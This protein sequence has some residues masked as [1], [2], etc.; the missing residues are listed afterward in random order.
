MKPILLRLSGLQS[1]REMQE[2]DFARLC[3]AGVFGIFGS[4]GS[5]KSSIL[6]AMTLAL[7]GKVERAANGTQGIM[8][9]AEKQ[10]SVAFT[11][12]LSGGGE[13][14]RYRV[15][16]QFKRGGDVSVSNTLSRFVEITEEGEIVHADKLA[17]V[18]RMV[19][20]RIGLSMQDFTR[21]VVLP[22]GK[23]AEFLSLTGKDR[24]QMLQRL[25][26]LERFGDGLALKL[27][28]RM[29]TAEAALNEAA[30]EQLGL[31]D[32]SEAAIKAAEARHLQ[33]SASSAHARAALTEAE[34]R[35]A[36]Q[37]HVRE[38]QEELRAKEQLQSNLLI[39]APQVA[40]W[41]KELARLSAAE[42]LLPV[43]DAMES[44]EAAHAA[45]TAR[46]AAAEANY[47]QCQLAAA[48]AAKM[49]AEAE[50][51][52]A[53]AEPRLAHRLAELAAAR[54]TETE[55]AVIKSEFENG[56]RQLGEIRRQR[57]DSADQAAKAE[58][59]LVRAVN[60]QNELKTELKTA[61]LNKEERER[62][63][64]MQKRLVQAESARAQLEAA[65][66]EAKKGA[67]AVRLAR[68]A[69]G[70]AESQVK[71][72]ADAIVEVLHTLEP[73]VSGYKKI[74]DS[75]QMLSDRL[76]ECT[77]AARAAYWRQQRSEL[78]AQLAHGLR[79]GEACPVCGSCAHP[80]KHEGAAAG[81]Q[82]ASAEAELAAWE[83]AAKQCQTLAM[84]ASG[85]LA[86]VERVY[87]RLRESIP[88]G[89]SAASASGV[90]PLFAGM[91]EAAAALQAVEWTA[92][93]T[94]AELAASAER[95]SALDLAYATAEHGSEAMRI[96]LSNADKAREAA[97]SELTALTSVEAKLSA[98]DAE[99]SAAYERERAEWLS[100]FGW[101][102]DAAAA[103]RELGVF[104]ER[105]QAAEDIRAK[106][107]KSV[108]F[109]EE[110]TA[111]REA[112]RRAEQETLLAAAQ[113]E[114][115]LDGLRDQLAQRSEQLLA[116][117]GG[118]AVSV[119]TAAA[120]RELNEI[121]AH[122]KAAKTANER[123]QELL[124]E[125]A[126]Q[127]IAAS[128][129]EKS[130]KQRA[131]ECRLAW[132]DALE[133]S[134]FDNSD[135][136]RHLRSLLG[137]QE[138]MAAQ[139][140]EYR[141]A[142]KELAAQ[143]SL[144]SS[145]LDGRSVSDEEWEACV[146][147]LQ[148]ARGVGETALAE[149]A[150]AER[151][152][153]DLR[154]KQERWLKLEEKRAAMEALCVRLKSLQSVFRGNAFVEYVAE[155]QLVQVCR[156]ASERLGYLTKRRYALE[157]DSGGGFVIRDDANGGIR[158]PVSTLSGGETFLASLALALALSG[159]IQL[160]GKYPLQFFFLDEGFGTLDPELLDT[161]IT[162]LEKL[163][164]DRLSVGV[165]SHVPE[166]RARLPRR[167]IVTAAEPSGRGSSVAL[168]TM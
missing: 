49:A 83:Q 16:R 167:L 101:E 160:R 157:V 67:E 129:S 138:R 71:A 58:E 29:K 134:P 103:R 90:E 63:A 32:A 27:N 93:T 130:L 113:L 131:E 47:R 111:A 155:E 118:E 153:E 110:K 148:A 152:L 10:L 89:R 20:S 53:E 123:G 159:Q 164:N 56:Q 82:A 50:T 120:E 141:E 21:A 135:E 109:I 64:D 165:I 136:T 116:C 31:G 26:R 45:S 75:L 145:Q 37:L 140:A 65:S 94:L 112:H 150:K 114:A 162:A 39:Q 30:A 78:A 142:E 105:E 99:L 76:P 66:T 12:E 52:S 122:L 41:E 48:E 125:E 54:K 44:A 102:L 73:V 33:A 98:K 158:R 46:L 126:E 127:R 60:R 51:A 14:R 80:A 168:E 77:E 115:K 147:E 163:H 43:L 18:T 119:L 143:I 87:E 8:N 97:A 85:G 23:F 149:L 137:Q 86:R 68:E 25:F 84:K 5:G 108:G 79:E 92:E 100:H 161:V 1:Y 57:Q 166:L 6:D 11:F 132:Q 133:R 124:R 74:S 7:Y 42:R 13:L 88:S 95:I 154:Q 106:L 3:E 40:A 139:I 24:R 144:L 117:T 19:E 4:T 9:Q 81:R 96:A 104:D 35:H 72:S 146:I 121:R 69:L 156:A 91:S 59:L 17:D 128:E 38:R 28:Q 151:D 107:E 62:R 34:R 22:Q 2:V 61:E 36:E 15:E 55:A 70:R